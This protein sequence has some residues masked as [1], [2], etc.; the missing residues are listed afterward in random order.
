MSD[1]TGSLVGATYGLAWH[2]NPLGLAVFKDLKKLR[3][4]SCPACCSICPF[5]AGLLVDDVVTHLSGGNPRN[6]QSVMFLHGFEVNHHST[7][8]V[9]PFDVLDEIQVGLSELAKFGLKVHHN[10]TLTKVLHCEEKL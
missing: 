7:S 8:Q 1:P 5:R 4:P 2:P 10:G 9:V 3:V 6:D